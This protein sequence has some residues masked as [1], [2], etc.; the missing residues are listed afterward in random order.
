M[1]PQPLPPPQKK[2]RKKK[3]KFYH[4]L[5]LSFERKSLKYALETPG[6]PNSAKFRGGC[7]SEKG[8]VTNV[9]NFLR[10]KNIKFLEFLR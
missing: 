4:S 3:K 6:A 7:R 10:D 5:S 1:I 8:G 2:R 9:L